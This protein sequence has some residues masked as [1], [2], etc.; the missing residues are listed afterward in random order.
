MIAYEIQLALMQSI[1]F[2]DNFQPN[3]SIQNEHGE[4]SSCVLLRKVLKPRIMNLCVQR[5]PYLTFHDA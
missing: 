3:P 1:N 2:D 4:A 5:S